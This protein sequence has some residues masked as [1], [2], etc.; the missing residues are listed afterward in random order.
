MRKVSDSERKQFERIFRLS[1]TTKP[2]A[3]PRNPKKPRGSGGLDGNTQDRLDRGLIARARTIR[4]RRAAL[5]RITPDGEALVQQLAAY[6][7]ASETALD[8]VLGEDKPA[9]LDQLR[10]IQAAL[11]ERDRSDEPGD[12]L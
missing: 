1:R 4:D 9:F 3:A 8:R 7:A 6:A 10:R 2:T 5:L 11:A 12:D